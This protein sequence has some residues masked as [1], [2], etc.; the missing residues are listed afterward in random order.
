MSNLLEKV[1]VGVIAAGTLSVPLAGV[2][3]GEPANPNPVGP[4]GLPDKIAQ[5]A[6]LQG[7]TVPPG[8]GT[9]LPHA[10][11]DTDPELASGV[12]DIAELPGSVRETLAQFN[13]PVVGQVIRDTRAACL[14][15]S[16][17]AGHKEAAAQSQSFI[18]AARIP[19]CWGAGGHVID[20]W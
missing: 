11:P 19:R 14:N 20:E 1:L 4:G 3:G 7:T 6:G 12:S 18:C 17:L 15:G 16:S 10:D 9:A 5:V 8:T 13:Q 2:A